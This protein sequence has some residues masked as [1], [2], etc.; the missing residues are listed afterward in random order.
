MGR[1]SW[2]G[3]CPNSL[4]KVEVWA[5]ARGLCS[6]LVLWAYA[7]IVFYPINIQLQ[8]L[9]NRFTKVNNELLLCVA[10][11]NLSDSFIAFDKQN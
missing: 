7:H 5:C 10:S 6:G 9:N 4:H 3:L 11:Q 8:K 2:L 1:A